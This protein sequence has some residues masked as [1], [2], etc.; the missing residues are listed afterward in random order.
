M[1]EFKPRGPTASRAL[2]SCPS[3]GWG[4]V[5]N[6]AGPGQGKSVV[7]VDRSPCPLPAVDPAPSRLSSAQEPSGFPWAPNQVPCAVWVEPTAG[8]LSHR[9]MRLAPPPTLTPRSS[10][11]AVAPGLGD[12]ARSQAIGGGAAPALGRGDWEFCSP[13]G[14]PGSGADGRQVRGLQGLAP[15]LLLLWQDPGECVQ[16][17]TQAGPAIRSPYRPRFS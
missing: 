16:G 4:A 12:P 10:V 8:H 3:G 13:R 5:K 9:S 2:P 6:R 14:G 7:G 15:D 11:R 1:R 17:E